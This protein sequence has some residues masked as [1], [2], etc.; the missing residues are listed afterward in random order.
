MR[1]LRS[2]L[3]IAA[4]LT[5]PLAAGCKPAQPHDDPP[6]EISPKRV[7][8][9]RRPDPPPLWH[10]DFNAW[11]SRN[12][13]KRGKAFNAGADGLTE[14]DARRRAVK[15]AE[16]QSQGAEIGFLGEYVE[17]YD[18]ASYMIVRL[19]ERIKP[20]SLD[21]GARKICDELLK[22]IPDDRKAGVKTVAVGSFH[23]KDTRSCSEFSELLRSTMLVALQARLGENAMGREKLLQTL[24]GNARAVWD[25]IDSDN[26]ET[27]DNPSVDAL[28]SGTFWPSDNDTV[29]VQASIKEL[30]TT[31]LL[32]G[33]SAIIS[34][35]GIAVAIRPGKGGDG[36]HKPG[37]K[38]NFKM[39]LWPK[40]AQ[41]VWR[42]GEKFA[43]NFRSERDCY[44]NLLHV[45]PSGKVQLLFPNQWHQDA[46]VPGGRDHAIPGAD[47]NFDWNI[48]APFGVETIM[49][50]ATATK[51]SGLFEF[52]PG[53]DVAFRSIGDENIRGLEVVAKQMTASM[54]KLPADQKAEKVIK[55]TTVGEKED[56][57]P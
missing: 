1:K 47:M 23:Y 38:Q 50:I 46:F 54:E 22:N 21:E 52:R 49:A 35:K 39:Q 53:K 31:I 15:E 20:K 57:A 55:I 13:D 16:K 27:N 12:P 56:H 25:I 28:I 43:V 45:D 26:T 8:V 4:M 32:G 2:C 14:S 11:L 10:T 51:T 6:P 9:A 33:G 41:Q 30:A 7:V 24:K 48:V 42:S 34:A 19:Y 40:D 36:P 37:D 18:D 3:I 5:A 44:L 17:W 29:K